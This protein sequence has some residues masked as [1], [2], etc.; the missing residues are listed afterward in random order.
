MTLLFEC[1]QCTN[2]S[3]LTKFNRKVMCDDVKWH[4]ARTKRNAVQAGARSRQP[5]GIIVELYIFRLVIWPAFERLM[6]IRRRAF[7]QN[8]HDFRLNFITLLTAVACR[9]CPCRFRIWHPIATRHSG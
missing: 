9:L 7:S 3:A 6:T 4:H 5:F 2:V 1:V 8:D